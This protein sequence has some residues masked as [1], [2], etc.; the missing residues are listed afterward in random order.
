M[1]KKISIITPAWN[2]AD[3]L[4]ELVSQ[5]QETMFKMKEFDWELIVS[6]NGST[7]DLGIA[8]RAQ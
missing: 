2:E 5:V 1:K 7:D 6:E 3:N 8:V 4:P